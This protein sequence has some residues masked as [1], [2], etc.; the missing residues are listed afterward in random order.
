MSFS[1]PGSD[2]GIT[3][4]VD[5]LDNPGVDAWCRAVAINPK[6]RSVLPMQHFREPYPRD[7]QF[8][9][10]YEALVALAQ[11]LES[12]PY[13]LPEPVPEIDQIDQPWCNRCHRHFTHCHETLRS[14]FSLS[15]PSTYTDPRYTQPQA[16]LARLNDYVHIVEMYQNIWPR[17]MHTWITPHVACLADMDNDP[18]DLPGDYHSW[19]HHDVILD[20]YILGK[21]TIC[22]FMD[23]D[24]PRDWD[25]TGHHITAGGCLIMLDDHRQRIYQSKEFHQWMSKYH[26]T[27][28][29]LHGDFP[30]G[31][32]V[33]GDRER[34]REFWPNFTRDWQCHVTLL[35]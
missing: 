14:Q 5:L 24:D 33:P 27:H 19:Q 18:V 30:L 23:D 16:L 22:S 9:H 1:L 13:R 3:V 17:H 32:L 29:D 12:T 11:E 15:D 7:Q 26:V 34:L 4:T 2:T 25:T 8:H 35:A 6:I 10:N 28:D 20:A 31:D 21:T